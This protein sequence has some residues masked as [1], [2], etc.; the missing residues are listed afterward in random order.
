[1]LRW[2]SLPPRRRPVWR[3]DQRLSAAGE[4]AFTDTHRDP[5]AVFSDFRI[6]SSADAASAVRRGF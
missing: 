3:P 4:G 6:F 2:L 1:R 5:Q